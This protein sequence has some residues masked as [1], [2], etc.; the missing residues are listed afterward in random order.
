MDVYNNHYIQRE[1]S[2]IEYVY[3]WGVGV[4]SHIVAERNAFSLPPSIGPERI[5][6]EYNG[7]SLTE[8]GNLVNGRR[9]DILAAYNAAF[10]PDLTEVPAWTPLL[11][12]TVHPAV[13]VPRSSRRTPGLGAWVSASVIRADRVRTYA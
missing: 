4:E 9:V 6:G 3:S 8:N 11:R 7:T 2:R 13:A 1:N 10:D 5:I 12:R